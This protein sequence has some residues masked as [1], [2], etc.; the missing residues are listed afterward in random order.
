VGDHD[1]AERAHKRS[2]WFDVGSD[3]TQ[4]ILGYFGLEGVQR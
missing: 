3:L 2:R 1:R 4:Q